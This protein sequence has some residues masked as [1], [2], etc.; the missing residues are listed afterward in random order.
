[1]QEKIETI[2]TNTEK[3]NTSNAKKNEH[4]ISRS[5]SKISVIWLGTNLPVSNLSEKC[6]L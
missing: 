3:G 1:M 2:N 4:N 6:L 5:I